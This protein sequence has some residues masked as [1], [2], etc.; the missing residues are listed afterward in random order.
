MGRGEVRAASVAWATAAEIAACRVSARPGSIEPPRQ[1]VKRAGE[2]SRSSGEGDSATDPAQAPQ[3]A[4]KIRQA[5]TASGAKLHAS[6]ETPRDG[7]LI[8]PYADTAGRDRDSLGRG[9][10]AGE[11]VAVVVADKRVQLEREACWSYLQGAY[12]DPHAARATLDD[13]LTR[14]G[15]TSAA[16]RVA[17]EPSQLGQLRGNVGWLASGSAKQQRAHAERAAGAL[18]GSVQ[19]IG[20]AQGAAARTYRSSVDMQRAADRTGIPRLS[21]QAESAIAALRTPDDAARGKVWHSMEKSSAIA[22]ELHAFR[23]AVERRFGVDGVR[24]MLHVK[25]RVGGV[26]APS[27]GPEQ[28]AAL[29]QVAERI[30]SLSSGERAGADLARRQSESERMA[31]RLGMRL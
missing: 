4:P 26:T 15:W 5:A 25:G 29:D 22:A 10:T 30:S 21:A 24:E 27:L 19:Q 28:R 9:T 8:P 1:G 3:A 13:L 7:W 12:R 16:S 2:W 23:E 20:D 14:E 18:P 17:R 6:T 31:Q 11:I